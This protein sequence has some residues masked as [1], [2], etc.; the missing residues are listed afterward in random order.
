MSGFGTCCF[1]PLEFY[2]QAPQAT[3]HQAR[4][5]GQRFGRALEPQVGHPAQ[6][7]AEGDLALHPGERRAQAVVD[8]LAERE[9]FVVRAR[10]EEHTSEL[11]SHS[12]L[13]C[14]LLLEK[15]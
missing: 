6:Q 1:W 14:R 8:A 2:G 7:G 11:Q 15:K 4:A 3:Q 9:V 10:S 12:E 5:P 13:V